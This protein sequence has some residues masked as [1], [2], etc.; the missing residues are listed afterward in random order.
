MPHVW[1]ILGQTLVP[2]IAIALEGH[3][4][5]LRDREVIVAAIVMSTLDLERHHAIDANEAS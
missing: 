5:L 1:V 2:T 4:E 3:D